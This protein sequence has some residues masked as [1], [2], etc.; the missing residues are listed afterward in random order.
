VTAAP[1]A[2]PVPKAPNAAAPSAPPKSTAPAAPGAAKA[3]APQS[4]PASPA[5]A[6]AA[7]NADRSGV[8]LVEQAGRVVALGVILNGDGR[9]VTS[10]SRLGTG[11]LFV[12]YANNT[13]EPARVGH[14]DPKRDL[15]LLVPR[16]AKVQKGF[17][18]GTEGPALGTATVTWF[19]VAQN[20]GLT[21]ST[22]T[23]QGVTMQA[24]R[25]VLKLGSAPKPNEFGG[26]L[27]DA[28]GDT[29]GIIVSGC[30]A[31]VTPCTEAPVAL[32][33]TEVRNF[34]KA[35]PPE[36][37]FALP[38]LGIMGVSG[39]TGVVRGLVITGVE[40]KSPASTL[41]LR[42]GSADEGDILVAI[43]GVPV[44]SEGSLRS[45]LSRHIA[46]DRVELLVYG[47]DSGGKDGYRVLT[48][49]LA[50][51][52]MPAARNPPLPPPDATR[53]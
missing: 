19:S 34:L 53:K 10:L 32:P 7:T 4:A 33:V 43:A 37:G 18:A 27:L 12:R 3:G 6:T 11:Q 50:P 44:T 26:P 29:I 2:A 24:G 5:A 13:T 28:N 49:R 14:S 23:L 8:A 46:G 21:P 1:P 39:D 16:T 30:A 9:I 47:K 36:S 17:K 48:V 22:Q 52:E 20:R 35:R 45:E 25:G 31:G 15:A 40:P 41:G 38:R 42:A 51:P